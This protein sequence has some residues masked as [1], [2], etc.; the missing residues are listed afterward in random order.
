MV[1]LGKHRS[2]PID[3]AAAGTRVQDW[4]PLCWLFACER[5]HPFCGLPGKLSLKGVPHVEAPSG[6]R[7]QG[8]CRGSDNASLRLER[9]Q[10]GDCSETY[11]RN[12]LTVLMKAVRGGRE[13]AREQSCS[14]RGLWAWTAVARRAAGARGPPSTEGQL[15]LLQQEAPDWP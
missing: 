1:S 2:S 15:R 4:L 8:C 14:Q 3:L 6:L 12:H 7:S 11:L 10:N 5:R 9:K 13:R